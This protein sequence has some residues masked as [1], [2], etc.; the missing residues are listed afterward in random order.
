MRPPTGWL[1]PR[2]EAGSDTDVKWR[3]KKQLPGTREAGATFTQHLATLFLDKGLE[4]N[5]ALPHIFKDFKAG[6]TVE[7][8]IDDFYGTGPPEHAVTFSEGVT[9][10]FIEAESNGCVHRR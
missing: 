2:Q 6:V 4:R 5:E 9:Q 7:A 3:L 1:W 10:V 8:H